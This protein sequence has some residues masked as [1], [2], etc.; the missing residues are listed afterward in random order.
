MKKIFWGMLLIMVD[1]SI[2]NGV[3]F[4][5]LLPDFIGVL[6]CLWG[7]AQLEF[8]WRKFR[9]RVFFGFYAFYTLADLLIGLLGIALPIQLLN[10][11][12]VLSNVLML[13]LTFEITSMI[14]H[15]ENGGKDL[16]GKELRIIWILLCVSQ[17]VTTFV[18][19]VNDVNTLFG[20]FGNAQWLVAMLFLFVMIFFL[21][22]TTLW[23]GYLY[24][25]A[26]QYDT[27]SLNNS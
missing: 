24:L 2:G 7:M 8:P 17:C 23:L 4:I 13:Y 26:R 1:F 12:P 22:S 10:G 14:Q 6:L 20:A 9:M 3:E 27:S 21:V 5:D 16:Y 11:L 18:F 19:L 15:M 25:T